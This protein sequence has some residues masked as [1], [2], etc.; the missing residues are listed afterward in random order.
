MLTALLWIAVASILFS[1]TFAF[2][3]AMASSRMSRS[4]EWEEP[5][6]VEANYAVRISK[7]A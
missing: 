1:G 4:H 3:A 2:M 6:R 5:I 7:A